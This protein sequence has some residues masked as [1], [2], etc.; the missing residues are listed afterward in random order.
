MAAPERV[1]AA[2][3]AEAGI[4]G[5][6]AGPLRAAL[7]VL[8]PLL[9]VF[10]Y[11][12]GLDS[13]HIPGI[14]DEA[15]YTQIA[16][17]TA[18]SGRWL[19]LRWE[20]GINDTKPPMLFWQAIVTTARGTHFNHW[21]LRGPIVLFSLAVALLAGLLAWRLSGRRATGALAGMIYL[22]F[23]STVQ[24]GRPFLINAPETFF[25]FAP[26]VLVMLLPRPGL[27]AV[28]ACGLC[29]GMAAL[30]KSF[31]LVAA[32]TAG[33]G[34][35]LLVR[36]DLRP[37]PWLR[38]YG[39]FC[40]AIALIGLALFAL[41][42]LL[43]PDPGQVLRQF[44]GHENAGKFR[45]DG[46]V[47]GLF[48]GRY[49]LLRIWL[50]DFANAGLYAVLLAGFLVLTVRR[51]A[52]LSPPERELW[53]YVLA[54][55]VV[56]SFPAQR[57]ENY[58]LPSCA[59][60]AVLMALR[61]ESIGAAWFVASHALVGVVLLL[62]LGVQ[63]RIEQL[64]GARLFTAWN[65]GTVALGL[66]L[67]A[68]GLVRGS[69]RRELFPLA[70]FVVLVAESS[71]LQPFSHRFPEATCAQLRGATV[72]FPSTSVESQ[73]KYR[74]VLPGARVR[75][76]FGSPLPWLSESTFVAIRVPYG[77]PL[78]AGVTPVDEIRS[79]RTRHSAR[80]LRDMIFHGRFDLLADRL[81][82]VRAVTGAQAVAG[83]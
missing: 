56:Y 71:F 63:L 9:A 21:T 77:Q 64:A 47:G 20:H 37:G 15:L 75:G 29:L 61:W 38:R 79:L 46:F 65:Y 6:P 53:G 32:G 11:F 24:Q 1:R 43:D 5:P 80:E 81:V 42:P 52:S 26:L 62:S 12:F 27:R 19:P 10:A 34:S 83:P 17:V 33:V 74:F 44:V 50:G 13:I 35:A 36:S 14:G 45:W 72:Y 8:G 39:A 54:F 3:A 23:L 49:T 82:I 22:G 66:L 4:P 60:L 58:V 40:L 68:V 59:A 73:E 51:R 41:W 28:L 18:E 25:L 57:Q 76:Y 31:F 78:P 30:Y 48:T 67:V 7:R 16:R 2:A 70:V 69:W 55:L